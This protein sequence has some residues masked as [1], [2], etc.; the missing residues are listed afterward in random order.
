MKFYEHCAPYIYK[1]LLFFSMKRINQSL[2]ATRIMPVFCDDEPVHQNG[3]PCTWPFPTSSNIP[4][5]VVHRCC[6]VT[7]SRAVSLTVSRLHV[8]LHEMTFNFSFFS[9]A[10]SHG[11]GG[12]KIATICVPVITCTV[13]TKPWLRQI[14]QRPYFIGDMRPLASYHTVVVARVSLSLLFVCT[15]IGYTLSHLHWKT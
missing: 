4:R 15:S 14:N 5:Y 3:S 2:G 8:P 7:A 1:A 11:A 12:V 9:K 10:S 13:R 6:T